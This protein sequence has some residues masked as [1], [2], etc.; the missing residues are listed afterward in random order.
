MG[1]SKKRRHSSTSSSSDSYEWKAAKIPITVTQI[2]INCLQESLFEPQGDDEF[3]GILNRISSSKFGVKEVF[4]LPQVCIMLYCI[5]QDKASFTHLNPNQE[6]ITAGSQIGSAYFPK[7]MLST[8]AKDQGTGHTQMHFKHPINDGEEHSSSFLEDKPTGASAG[9]AEVVEERYVTISDI[10]TMAARLLKAELSGNKEK[11]DKIKSKL[12]RLREAQRRNVKVRLTRVVSVSPKE[13]KHCSNFAHLATVDR[14]GRSPPLYIKESKGSSFGENYERSRC[15]GGRSGRNGYLFD[16]GDSCTIKEMIR[17]E[18]LEMKNSCDRQFASLSGRCKDGVDDEYGDTFVNENVKLQGVSRSRLRSD[19]ITDYKRREYAESTCSSC[20]DHTPRYLV[21]S[22]RQSMFLSL[23]EHASL[24][25]GH[26][27]LTPLE[28]VGAMTRVDEAAVE[29]ARAFKRDLCRM[30]ALWKGKGA[31]Y[32][33][34]EKAMLDLGSEWDQNKRILSLERS[35]TGVYKA[36]PPNFGYFCVEFG[37]DGGG[38][39]KVIEDWSAFPLHFGREVLAGVLG[40]SVDKWRKPKKDPLE[41]LRRKAV[42]F[43]EKWMTVE[44]STNEHGSTIQRTEIPATTTSSAGYHLEP[45]GPELP[46]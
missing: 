21:M 1:K 20:M 15:H 7:K 18:K 34:M 30:A 10:N 36:I 43:E 45:E 22:V 31:S 37:I 32:V 9:C 11:M 35:G 33:F 41:Q 6:K 16:G 27:F 17:Q 2:Y 46:P 25:R 26:C 3:S 44:K 12:E 5:A 19:A 42:E 40:K 28:H 23:P 4:A 24:S 39:A 29:E 13:A 38:Y 14:D 8:S